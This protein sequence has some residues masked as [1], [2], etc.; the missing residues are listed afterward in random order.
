M[1]LQ[2]LVFTTSANSGV[3]VRIRHPR[4]PLP[5][6]INSRAQPDLA[7]HGGNLAWTAVHSGFEVQIDDNAPLK[8][9]TGVIY[10]VPAGDPGDPQLQT[11]Q[12]GPALFTKPWP[13]S[14]AWFEYEIRT[15][16]ANYEVKLGRVGDPKITTTF[17][18]TSIQLGACPRAQTHSADSSAYNR[19]TAAGWIQGIFKSEA[20]ICERCTVNG[21]YRMINLNEVGAHP[22]RDAM[23]NWRVKLASICRASP[24]TRDI[25]SKFVS[26][27]NQTNSSIILSP[28]SSG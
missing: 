2:F 11:T 4:R 23:S 22:Q 17:F 6:P 15:V 19:I 13:D 12:P 14:T 21:E 7:A 20:V 24:S 8:N 28:S 3:F 5:E 9:R 10:D 18:T 26:F 1:K 25:V 27:M 16:N